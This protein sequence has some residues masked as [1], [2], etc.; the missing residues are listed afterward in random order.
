ALVTVH[1]DLHIIVE[2]GGR[3]PAEVL[4]GPHVFADRGLE[5]LG[6]HETQV[7]PP[8]VAQDVT[9]QVDSLPALLRKVD[10][11]GGVI[12]LRLLPLAALE[13]HYRHAAPIG[14]EP[15]QQ[16][17]HDRVLAR[18][19]RLTQLLED[20]PRRDARPAREKILDERNMPIQN[21]AARFR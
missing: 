1:H 19:T 18:K 17:L 6:L 14:T 3:H 21:A 7:L 2:A 13:T 11:V 9:E 20:A 16:V 5:V 15:T 12:H 10:L 4:E 8:R